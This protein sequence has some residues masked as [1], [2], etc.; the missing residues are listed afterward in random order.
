MGNCFFVGILIG[1]HFSYHNFPPFIF[2]ILVV[3]FLF[4]QN[5]FF[6]IVFQR[7]IW[8]KTILLQFFL[9]RLFEYHM[10]INIFHYLYKKKH[11]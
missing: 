11:V 8:T 5:H 9:E 1:N 10:F 4:M 3:K 7:H 6:E 2:K